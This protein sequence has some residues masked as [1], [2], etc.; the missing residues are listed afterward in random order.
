MLQLAISLGQDLSEVKE[1]DLSGKQL[2]ELPAEFPWAKLDALRTL[3]LDGNNLDMLPG[4]IANLPLLERVQLEGNPLRFVPQQYRSP[5]PTLRDYI[6]SIGDKARNWTERK[7]LFVGQ[8]G[9]GKTTLL[10]VSTLPKY[11]RKA[12][13]TGAGASVQEAEGLL[14]RGP[15]YRRHPSAPRRLHRGHFTAVQRL[16]LG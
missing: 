2:N 10:K 4:A 12:A 3:D 11:C 9:V 15:L 5:W 7:L 16:G 6:R 1:L 13:L 8:D 14:P